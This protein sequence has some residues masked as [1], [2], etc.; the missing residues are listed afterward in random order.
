MAMNQR[1]H[2]AIRANVIVITLLL[3]AFPNDGRSDDALPRPA[4]LPPQ[5]GLPDP[6]V[7]LDGRKVSSAEMWFKERRPELI[8]LFQ[9]YMY[10][11]LP[12]S[13]DTV[14]GVVERVDVNFF[15]GKATL[16]EVT[17]R[18]GPSKVPPIHLMLVVPNKRTAPAPV[19]L[20]MNYFGNHTLVQDPRVRL[21]DNWMPER[22]EGVVENHAT[23]A[24]RG[25]WVEIWRIEEVI[26]RGYA[27]ATFYNGD[28]DPDTPDQ[29]GLQ[30]YF[31]TSDP[32]DACGT[33][34]AWAWGLQ[35]AVDYLMAA[36]GIDPQRIVVTGHSRLSK[37]ALLAAAFDER[38]AMAIPHQA[39]CGGSAPSRARIAIDKPWNTLD[40]PQTKPPETVLDINQMFPRWF[41]ARFK[42]FNDQPERLPIDQN[43]LVALCAPRP[44]LFTNGRADTWINPAGQFEVLRAAAP[45]YRLLGAGD[46][47]AEELPADGAPIPGPLGYALRPGGHSLEREDWQTFCDFADQHSAPSPGEA[48][49]GYHDSPAGPIMIDPEHPRTFRHQNGQRFFPMGD[50]AYFLMGRPADAIAHFIDVRRAHEFNFIRI[51]AMGDGFWPFGGTPDNPDYT[52]IEEAAF[53]KMDWVFDYAAAR[54]MNIELILWGYGVAGGEGLWGD[55]R[56]EDLWIETLVQRYRDRPNL[57][58]YTIANEF[59]RYPDGQYRY[60]SSDVDWARRVAAR[61]RTL[62][63]VHSI[64]CHPS[65][66]ITDQ[67]SPG[68]GARPFDSY[69]QFTQRRPQVVWPLWESSEA[70]LNVTQNNE[71]VQ[72]RGWG[73]L[74]DGGHGLTYYATS[75]QEVDYPAKWT[76]T[77]WDFEAAGL[78]DCI[79][80]DGSRG[81]PVLDTEFG[82]QYEPGY[83][84]A[85]NQTTRQ[86][87]QPSTVRKKAWKIATAGGYFAAGFVGTAVSR[88]WTNRDVDNFRPAALETLYKF[89]TRTEYWKLSPHLELVASHNALLAQPGEEYVAYFPRGGANSIDLAAGSYRVE[90][91]QP[92]SGEYFQQRAI[93]VSDG[94]QSFLP[95]NEP[96]HDWVLHLMRT[97]TR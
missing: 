29:R 36:S 34:G 11:E 83:D 91:L 77:G 66:W 72:R 10:G 32:A 24:S 14:S 41:N 44:V 87:H 27:V 53:R 92:E 31:P 94:D 52:V 55:E 42:E 93:T 62:D 30:R 78:E 68:Q 57:F 26:D 81:K 6:L 63:P 54:D 20:G 16:S 17:I 85:P 76:A 61:I 60:E 70:N 46:F 15:G 23:D 33:I 50:T 39:G 2:F 96:D 45:V 64:G 80:E 43:C 38:I 22:G 75:W 51:M 59:E 48:R 71:G 8:R 7:M 88:D 86:S 73:D 4:D 49:V 13:P 19:I 82:Y 69:K 97:E 40:T 56:R 21:A 1:S 74:G 9:H 25:S 79:A 47:K 67:D 35:R 90:W 37:A 58:M 18:F 12:P 89:F 3:L 84:S 5:A 95:P 65:V 28:I